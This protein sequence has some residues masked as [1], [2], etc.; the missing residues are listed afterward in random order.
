MTALAKDTLNIPLEG[1]NATVIAEGL[2]KLK[3]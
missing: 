1:G 3:S 2:K